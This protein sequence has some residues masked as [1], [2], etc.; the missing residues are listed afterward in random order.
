MWV[1]LVMLSLF[2]DESSRA[3]PAGHED[4]H[5]PEH[6]PP[7]MIP[8][9]EPTSAHI[10]PPAP[11]GAPAMHAGTVV[12]GSHG[13]EIDY[14]VDHDA[15]DH[16]TGWGG[17]LTFPVGT[18]PGS[19]HIPRRRVDWAMDLRKLAPALMRFRDDG[20][21]G[22]A[23]YYNEGGRVGVEGFFDN[24]NPMRIAKMSGSVLGGMLG[25][26][27]GA[28]AGGALAGLIAD[29]AGAKADVPRAAHAQMA[30][31]ARIYPEELPGSRAA[32]QQV[33]MPP[34]QFPPGMMPPMMPGYAPGMMGSP[35]QFFRQMSPMGHHH[36]DDDDD[37][38][39]KIEG[40]RRSGRWTRG[41]DA[42]GAGGDAAPAADAGA[43]DAIEGQRRVLRK[44][45]TE[46]DI[47]T[48]GG[49]GT[50]P[51][52]GTSFEGHA[53]KLP[54]WVPVFGA[55]GL[56]AS[57]LSIAMQEGAPEE[58]IDLLRGVVRLLDI[59][60]G[61]LVGSQSAQE[62]LRTGPEE[63]ERPA[64]HLADALMGRRA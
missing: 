25:G 60:C 4:H 61:A 21:E 27:L 10:P 56:A 23:A 43:G 17:S 2:L 46:A 1:P 22:L 47:R 55:L 16:G 12:S 45:V 32:L 36:H 53:H 24:I 9:P 40:R 33:L 31:I 26:P 57:A 28:Q 19:D 3:A 50:S 48:G 41:G 42:G 51:W 34:G 39:D 44:G 15:M 49:T 7:P 37:E 18:W 58:L 14:T 20:P 6:V 38:K 63:S 13:P 35:A 5:E 52:F 30:Q 29:A 59:H 11:L 62:F 54:D 64:W 8:A